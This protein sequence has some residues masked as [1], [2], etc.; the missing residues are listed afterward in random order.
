MKRVAASFTVVA[1]A[2]R[3]SYAYSHGER[4]PSHYDFLYVYDATADSSGAMKP[5]SRTN[6]L[7]VA[8]Y[9]DQ[10]TEVSDLLLS[11]TGPRQLVNRDSS[12]SVIP[13]L[14][15]KD[16]GDLPRKRVRTK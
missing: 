10:S 15:E 12:A 7:V 16:Q 6:I 9:L 4:K 13:S 5:G 1:A 14:L 11:R 3:L 2:A 8:A